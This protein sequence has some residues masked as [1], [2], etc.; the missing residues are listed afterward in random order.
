MTKSIETRGRDDRLRRSKEA[1]RLRE[2]LGLSAADW[3][4][5]LWHA[6][7]GFADFEKAQNADPGWALS[8]EEVP[9][10]WLQ[11]PHAVGHVVV[12]V[13][14]EGRAALAT[15]VARYFFEVFQ[16]GSEP[17][18]LPPGIGLG[19]LH[20]ERHGIAP[21]IEASRLAEMAL[22]D[23]K[24]FFF[25]VAEDDLLQLCRLVLEG[26]ATIEAWDLHALFAAVDRAQIHARAPFRLFDAL[27]SQEWVPLAARR[28]FCRGLLGCETALE[29]LAAWRE[30]RRASF[31][32]DP[33]R[34]YL[35]PRSVADVLDAGVG[36]RL[37]GL[38]RHA[39]CALAESLG[40]PVQSVIEEFFL[41]R[42]RDD[43]IESAVST[44]TLDLISRHA[45]VL[46]PQKVRKLLGQAIRRG[47]ADVRQAA[48]R[49]GAEQFGLEFARPARQDKAG[50]VRNWAVK[51]LATKTLKSG[52]KP[53]SSRR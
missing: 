36:W 7:N 12:R 47:K 25:G 26:R 30:S 14:R 38:G 53:A 40:V 44:G 39:V 52:R 32:A 23:P 5:F 49:A 27:V 20:L 3:Q 45:E 16:P 1:R 35:I 2:S 9:S 6:R 8:L 46:G 13:L 22:H 29:N 37:P 4:S 42:Y 31:I 17:P 50:L 34:L 18:L 43:L 48:Y 21:P 24:F 19:W 10:E 28:E 33:E 11:D 51:L 15:P 41:R